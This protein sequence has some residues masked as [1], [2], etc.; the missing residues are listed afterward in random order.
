MKIYNSCFNILKM[1]YTYILIWIDLL[2]SIFY[3]M[4]KLNDNCTKN[5]NSARQTKIS[6]LIK[7]RVNIVKA[8]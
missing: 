7:A 4:T 3:I 1:L 5:N 2:S 8:L 6:F